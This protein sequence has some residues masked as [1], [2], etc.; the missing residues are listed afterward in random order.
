MDTPLKKRG[1]LPL[2]WCRREVSRKRSAYLP[3]GLAYDKSYYNKYPSK[4]QHEN[5]LVPYSK[6]TALPTR[7]QKLIVHDHDFSYVVNCLKNKRN[8]VEF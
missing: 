4:K 8:A 5:P 1:T 2:H 6:S 7:F 3:Y